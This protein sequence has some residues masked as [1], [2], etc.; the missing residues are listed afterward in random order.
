MRSYFKKDAWELFRFLWI[1]YPD[2]FI[3]K[4]EENLKAHD[5]SGLDYFSKKFSIIQA[6]LYNYS[7]ETAI[8]KLNKIR[9]ELEGKSN[10]K[11]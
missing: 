9:N 11:R 10:G 6:F 4:L 7:H 5:F 3:K 1:Q 8:E 2:N